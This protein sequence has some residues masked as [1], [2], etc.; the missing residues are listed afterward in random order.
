MNRNG[1]TLIELMLAM[2]IFTVA[3]MALA[4]STGFM[5]L[6]LHAADLR[7]ERSVAHQQAMEQLRA[8]D[9]DALVSA[10]KGSGAQ[11]GDYTVWW[12]VAELQWALKEVDVYTEGPGFQGGR[13]EAA[14][15]D[16]MTLRI[17]RLVQ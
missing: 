12:N 13:R 14:V 5:S 8:E 4:S 11:I 10:S 17:A 7:T 3:V 16:T 1:F 9:F 6:Q 15:V 2:L